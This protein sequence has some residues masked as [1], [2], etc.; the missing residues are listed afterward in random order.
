MEFHKQP[1]NIN[2]TGTTIVKIIAIFILAYFMYL[3]SDILILFFVALV[4]SS[5]L[6]PWV[7]WLKK[8]KIPRSVSVL[9]IYLVI[10]G[11]LGMALY[12]IIP[13]IIKEVNDMSTNFPGYFNAIYLKFSDLKNYSSKY[14]VLDNIQGFLDFVSGYLQTTASGIFFTITNIFGGIFSFVLILVLTFYMVVEESAMKKLVWSVAPVRHQPYLMQLINRVQI[15]MGYWLRGQLILVLT[16]GAMA[17]IGLLIL[18]VN[19]ALIL[20]ILVGLFSF[21]PYMGAI[22]GAVPALLI[23]LTQS[24]L[25][26]A[27][28][29][30]LFVIIHFIEGNFL[31]PKVMEKAVGLNPIIS[32]MAMLAGFKLAGVIGAIL[33]IPVTTALAVFVK[34]IFESK[35]GGKKAMPEET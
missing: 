32:I 9:A 22:L 3:I 7:D 21:V 19:Y 23:S 26:A 13:L 1:I 25:L 11:V 5:S 29:I 6:D 30:V 28:V 31:Y 35:E 14:G 8:K 2:I 33:S 16:L 27:L 10:F 15:K 34:D 12:A 18:G 20:A 4:F 17:Y 24:P